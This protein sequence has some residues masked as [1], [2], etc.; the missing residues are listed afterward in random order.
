MLFLNP[1]AAAAHKGRRKQPNGRQLS[2]HPEFK[3]TRSAAL[4]TNSA[5]LP[6]GLTTPALIVAL[7]PVL[8][9]HPTGRPLLAP[10][11]FLAGWRTCR[12]GPTF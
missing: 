2:Q 7:Q 4:R 3:K 1:A 6:I 9:V 5:Y 11:F 8:T 12:I 10:V